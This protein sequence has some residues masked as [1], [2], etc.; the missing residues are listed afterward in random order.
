M[1]A[2]RMRRIPGVIRRRVGRLTVG[3]RLGNAFRGQ[4]WEG[5]CSEVEFVVGGKLVG[6]RIRFITVEMVRGRKPFLRNQGYVVDARM[7]LRVS[8]IDAKGQ[9]GSGFVQL[10]RD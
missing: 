1:F 7:V 3:T 6:N 4:V 2:L 9:T 8:G 10:H 5:D